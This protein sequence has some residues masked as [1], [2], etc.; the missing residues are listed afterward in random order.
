MT[1]RDNV[2]LNTNFDNWGTA[3]ANYYDDN[4][5]RTRDPFVIENN[6]WQQGDPDQ[7]KYNVTKKNNRLI[8]TL[9]QAPQAIVEAAGLEPQFRDLLH[10]R[11]GEPTAPAAPARVC[12]VP[13]DGGALVGWNPPTFNGGSPILSYTVIS[14]TGQKAEISADDFRKRGYA[15]LEGLT[16]GVSCTFIVRANNG[17]GPGEESIASPPVVIGSHKYSPP[18]AP[19]I[20][21]INVGDGAISVH[22]QPPP[23]SGPILQYVFTIN[24]GNRRVELSGRTAITLGGTHT[25]F[26][27]ID[28]LENGNRYTVS[29]S[30]INP[31][32]EGRATWSKPVLVE[33]PN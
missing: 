4:A 33:K 16:K 11:F 21:R 3:H 1:I 24:P 32:G 18:A 12:A 23:G 31:A 17:S 30:A 15:Q 22:F 6:Y 20:R 10:L 27:V 29:V 25:T 7:E 19:V 26:L 14:S 9:D 5:G 28:G 8:A 13:L 2:L